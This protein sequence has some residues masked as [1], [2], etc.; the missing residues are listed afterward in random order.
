ML[1]ERTDTVVFGDGDRAAVVRLFAEDHL[2]ECG[3]SRAVTPDKS[4]LLLALHFE[5][6]IA[7]QVLST[8]AFGEVGELYH[9]RVSVLGYLEGIIPKADSNNP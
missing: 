7:E 6:D 3:F 2:E 5:V 8:E 1:F 9:N 4:D